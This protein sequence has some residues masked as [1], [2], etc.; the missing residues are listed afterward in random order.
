M[1]GQAVMRLADSQQRRVLTVDRAKLDITN[2]QELEKFMIEQKPTSVIL[3]AAKVGGIY[4]NMS[5]KREFI[6]ENLA[7]Q[8]AVINA[9]HKS[10]VPRLVFL[11]SS[12]IYPKLAPQPITEASLLSGPL[13]ETNEAY[14]LAKIVGVK[15]CE[16][17]RIES[18]FEYFSLMPTNLYG[19]G[20]NFD[21]R[22]SHV[23]AA[24][25]RRFHEGK[26][27]SEQEVSIWGTGSPMREFMHVD[28]LA[29]AILFAHDNPP[30]DN[31]INVGSGSEITIKNFANLMRDVVGFNGGLRFDVSMPDGTPRKLLD[32]TKFFNLGWRP[33]ITL[34]KGL[35]STYKWFTKGLVDGIVRG[36]K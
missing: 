27:N 21:I 32:T 7:I 8:S 5:Q 23:P 22:N 20:D 31:L 2:Q 26:K 35:E 11:G 17:I 29:D 6:N 33:K 13:E 3:A 1:V 24:L 36:Y 4:A 14:A 18:G 12:C 19:P 28:D 25:M 16:Y 34:Q 15:L 10:G 30:S 9:A